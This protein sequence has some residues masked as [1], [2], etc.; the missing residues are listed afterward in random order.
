MLFVHP[1]RRDG[2][3]VGAVAAGIPLWRWSQRL[4]RQLQVDHA[5]QA[6][7]VLWVYAYKDD[8]L[9]HHGTPEL[10]DPLVPDGAARRA[11]L[12]R[13]PGGFTGQLQMQSRWYGYGVL[14]V[15]SLGEGAGVI[16]FRS[17]PM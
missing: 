16:V 9:F 14:P 6:G 12:E 7:L 2:A 11:G 5:D 13:S 1:V 15:P 17:N 3:V 4:S 10:L 8:R